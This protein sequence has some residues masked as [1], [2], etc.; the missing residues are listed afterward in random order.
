M[1][2]SLA[3]NNALSGLQANTRQAEVISTNVANAL[4]EGFGRRGLSLSPGAIS[5]VR[6]D[7]VVRASAPAL[8]EARRFADASASAA[9]VL[10]DAFTRLASA[11]GEPGGLAALATAADDLDAALAAAADTP[12]SPTLLKNAA[13]AA[14]DFSAS[15]NR[16]A[17]EAMK[18]RIS[19]DA[20]IA[21]QVQT[22]NASLS[23]IQSLNGEIKAKQLSGGDVSALLDQREV[24]I[25]EASG[26]IPIRTIERPFGEVAIYA[27]N[28]GQLLDGKVFELG[29]T[30]SPN[31]P[32]G[33]TVGNGGLSGLTINDVPIAIG[34]GDGNGLFDGGS[35]AASFEVRDQIATEATA[36]LDGLA[37]GLITRVQDLPEDATLS[38]GDAGIFTDGGTAFDPADEAGIALRDRKSVV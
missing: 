18:V 11:V 33:A 17:A 1:T 13:L 28:G 8:T 9:S 24:L 38:I 16:I 30:P 35:L 15:I 25:K 3:L 32:S 2:L 12:E 5:G 7:G 36:M 21:G 23:K 29:F 19:A 22:I 37:A 10:S 4:T 6:V 14:G 31:A 20:S 34:E 27:R 26:M